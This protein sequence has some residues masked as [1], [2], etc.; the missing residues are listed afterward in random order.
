MSPLM[1]QADRRPRRRRRPWRAVRGRAARATR[2]AHAACAKSTRASASPVHCTGV[3][4]GRQ[5]RQVRSAARYATLNPLTVG[6]LRLALAAS[7][8]TTHRRRRWRRSSIAVVRSRAGRSRERGRR[9]NSPRRAGRRRSRPTPRRRAP[10]SATRGCARGS[11]FS[12]AARTTLSAPRSASA[13]RRDYLHTRPARAAG[14]RAWRRRAAFRPHDCPRRLRLG[15]AGGA[16]TAST[17]A[18]ASWRPR[19]GR[20][21]REDAGAGLEQRAL[22]DP[23]LLAHAGQAIRFASTLVW[24]TRASRLRCRQLRPGRT[25]CACVSVRACSISCRRWTWCAWPGA[26]APAPRRRC[27][28]AR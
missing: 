9:G 8:S 3:L 16:P 4:V 6:A 28:T 7:R 24:W 10:R 2:R 27:R 17:F 23:L 22:A 18:S 20:R 25:T 26:R 19:S 21:V 14:A 15:G 13:C 12:R 5:L 1:T 11:R